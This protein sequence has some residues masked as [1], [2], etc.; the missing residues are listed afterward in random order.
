MPTLLLEH[1]YR[2]GVVVVEIDLRVG[3]DVPIAAIPNKAPG[4]PLSRLTVWT[5]L[6]LLGLISTSTL[7]DVLPTTIL[8]L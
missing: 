3:V 6:F 1:V 4:A 8:P 7:F 5:T 2:I